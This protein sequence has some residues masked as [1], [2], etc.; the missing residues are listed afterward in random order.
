MPSTNPRHL[1]SRRRLLALAAPLLFAAALPASAN[2][3]YPDRPIR[4]L[5]PFAPGGETDIFAHT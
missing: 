5:I 3:S 2:A 1:P 4:L